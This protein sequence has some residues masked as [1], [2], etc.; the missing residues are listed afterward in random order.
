MSQCDFKCMLSLRLCR[1]KATRLRSLQGRTISSACHT[2]TI[3]TEN[4]DAVRSGGPCQ[5]QPKKPRRVKDQE[6]IDHII[7]KV[8]GGKHI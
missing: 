3:E 6:F 8:G 2:K 1:T 4:G 5:G 7:L